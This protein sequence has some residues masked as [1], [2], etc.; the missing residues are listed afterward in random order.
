MYYIYFNFKKGNYYGLNNY[1][2]S[3]DWDDLLRNGVTDVDT[4]VDK[5]YEV[6]SIGMHNFIPLSIL[7]T[8]KF[9]RW[10]SNELKKLIIDK[11]KHHKKYKISNRWDDYLTFSSLRTQCKDSMKECYKNHVLNTELAIPGNIKTFW[12]FVNDKRKDCSMPQHM[13]LGNES[14]DNGST[15]VNL[16]SKHFKSVYK[17]SLVANNNTEFIFEKTVDIDSCD[18]S[19]ETVYSKLASLDP[20]KSPGPDG[21]S[22]IL[23]KNCRCSL[24]KPLLFLFT[25]S[26]NSGVFPKLWKN[27]FVTPIYK[28]GEK[29]N[30]TNYRQICILSTIP[31]IFENFITDQIKER[32]TMAIME[33]QHGFCKG[34]STTTNML[35]FV[36]FVLNA[37]ENRSQVDVVYTDF[38]KAFD[39][40]NHFILCEKLKAFGLGGTLLNW[41][42]SYLHDRTQSVRVKGFIS[43]EI[44]VTSGVPQGSHLG[45]FL[46]NIFI[47]DIKPVFKNSYFLL[48]ADDLKLFNIVKSKE[49][50]DNIQ[51]DLDALSRWCT[52]NFLD[53]NIKKCQSVSFYRSH[54]RLEYTYSIN[55]S[56]LDNVNMIRDLGIIMDTKLDFRS[57]YDHMTNKALKMLGFICRISKDFSNISSLTCLYNSLVRSNLEYASAVWSPT[58]ASHVYS[59]EKVQN[60]FL[61]FIAYKLNLPTENL[62]L[63]EIR[64]ISGLPELQ[65]RRNIADIVMLYKILNSYIDCPSLL[66]QIGIHVPPRESR[67]I[68]TFA[69]AHHRCNYGMHSP[70]SRIVHTGNNTDIDFFNI[71]LYSLKHSLK[72]LSSVS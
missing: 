65:T 7:K 57:H 33:E 27:S 44:T 42:T 63:K 13:F 46:F 40:V 20:N 2:A 22:P 48:F 19:L 39:T 17:P 69:L 52:L 66:F 21:I 26:L 31:K 56:S 54:S 14:S 67:N 49:D 70:I 71:S 9:P 36:Q 43:E 62:S 68:Q 60:K 35:L 29:A 72:Q 4:A 58:Y 45:P 16:F 32:L 34:R 37:L 41:I 8:P 64:S 50:C 61:R 24:A 30:I 3:I 38:S 5:F 53:L 1:L 11:K 55:G 10:Y 23:L 47:N 59:L 15:T 18:V 12:N 28:N 51:A 6:L 25:L